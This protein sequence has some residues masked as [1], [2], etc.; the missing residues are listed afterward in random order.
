[1]STVCFDSETSID[2]FLNP[3]NWDK[4]VFDKFYCESRHPDNFRFEIDGDGFLTLPFSG[5]RKR[6][7][8]IGL[9]GFKIG[10]ASCRERVSSP[11]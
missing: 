6:I 11:V 3:E 4:F 2:K 1:M 5:V 9:D 8:I 7:A 10:R